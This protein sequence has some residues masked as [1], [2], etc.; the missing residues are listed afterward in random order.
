MKTKK[1][2]NKMLPPVRIE[3][4]T[5]HSKSNTLLFCAYLAFACKTGTLGFLYSHALLILTKSSKS[6]N[7]VVYE[8]GFKDPLSSTCQVSLE[9]RVLDLELEVPGSILTGVNILSLELFLFSHSKATDA[10]TC[11][12]ANVVCL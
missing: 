5:S 2:R 4:G 6:N 7:Q 11:I 10:S 1:S 8:Q 9:R 3:P 12:I